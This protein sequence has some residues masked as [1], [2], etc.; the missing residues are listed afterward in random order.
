M[1]TLSSG[2]HGHFDLCWREVFMV[3]PPQY[4]SCLA[5]SSGSFGKS[6]S[7]LFGERFTAADTIKSNA[8]IFSKSRPRF[9]ELAFRGR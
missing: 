4:P 5:M 1:V 2:G 9:P 6:F 3:A 8:K 7:G